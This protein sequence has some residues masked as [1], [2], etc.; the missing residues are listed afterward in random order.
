MDTAEFLKLSEDA[1][2]ITYQLL[3][4]VNRHFK[5]AISNVHCDVFKLLVLTL[6]LSE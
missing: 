5:V 3:A 6:Y 2:Y 4:V 1:T